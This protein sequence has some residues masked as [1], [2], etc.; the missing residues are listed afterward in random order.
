MSFTAALLNK[1]SNVRT[2]ALTYY[3]LGFIYVA[4]FAYLKATSTGANDTKVYL[5]T[6][7]TACVFAAAFMV[8]PRIMW[9]LAERQSARRTMQSTDRVC[10]RPVGWKLAMPSKLAKRLTEDLTKQRLSHLISLCVRLPE[11]DAKEL[12]EHLMVLRE[13]P[14]RTYMLNVRIPDGT[15]FTVVFHAREE[16]KDLI[17]LD[18]LRGSW[19]PTPQE[20]FE[21]E[22]EFM[23]NTGEYEFFD[24]LTV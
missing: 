7:V 21:Q 6:A 23:L 8:M 22:E 4:P 16:Q 15:S 5:V 14:I 24:T 12:A 20:T 2:Q 11:L 13:K 19:R 10:M 3:V 1:T 18:V 9:M 17:I